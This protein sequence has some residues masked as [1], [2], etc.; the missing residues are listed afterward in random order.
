[1]STLPSVSFQIS[2]PVVRKWISGLAGLLN[3]CGMK[4][5]GILGQLFGLGDGPFHSFGARRE[6]QRGA[7][8]LEHHPPLHRHRVGHRQR[9]RVAFR[10]ADVGQRDARI[11]AGRLDDLHAR[12]QLA[13]LFGV[14]DHRRPDAALDAVGGIAAFDLGEDGGLEAFGNSIDLHERRATDRVGI[15]LEGGH[16]RRFLPEREL[17][18][19]ASGSRAGEDQRPDS[20]VID[21]SRS[22]SRP[23]AGNYR[24]SPTRLQRRCAAA[25]PKPRSAAVVISQRA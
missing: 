12:L 23:R 9:Q 6:H 13:G 14:P 2:G 20:Q 4:K 16:G 3:C 21:G 15:I 11:A 17:G 8:R 19:E 18:T 5:L 24:R 1:M 7:K 22:G 10:R 25:R